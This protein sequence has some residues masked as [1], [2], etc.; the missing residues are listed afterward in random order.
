MFFMAL[1]SAY[2]VLR[3]GT[4]GRWVPPHDVR[5]PVE[6]TALNTLL[7]FLSGVAL[8]FSGRALARSQPGFSRFAYLLALLLGTGFVIGQG[9]EWVGLIR[10]GMTMSSGLFGALFFLLIGSHGLHAALALLVMAWFF[11]FP[12]SGMTL[13]RLRAVQVFWYFIVGVWPILYGLVYF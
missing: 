3:A 4:T 1:V 11:V 7:L 9:Y 8:F 10:Y 2:I 6:A 13:D 5:L 12:G